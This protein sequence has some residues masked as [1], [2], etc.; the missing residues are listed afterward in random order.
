[1]ADDIIKHLNVV[2]S[3]YKFLSTAYDVYSAT[4]ITGACKEGVK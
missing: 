2:G 3:V 4:T 1:M